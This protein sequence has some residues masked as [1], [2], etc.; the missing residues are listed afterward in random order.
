MSIY[1][2]EGI[3]MQGRDIEMGMQVKYKQGWLYLAGWR[4]ANQH[5]KVARVYWSSST[6]FNQGQLD[7]QT[8]EFEIRPDETYRVRKR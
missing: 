3:E 8:W 5:K 1:D 7:T 6:K 4:R 2:I